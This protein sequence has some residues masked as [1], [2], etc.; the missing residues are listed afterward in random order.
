[1]IKKHYII[2]NMKVIIIDTHKTYLL[3]GSVQE[4]VQESLQDTEEIDNQS[5]F[6]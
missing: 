2:P 5:D 1:M 3:T 4:S 6:I